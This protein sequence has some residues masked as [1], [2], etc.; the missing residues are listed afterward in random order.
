MNDKLDLAPLEPETQ[1]RA[2]LGLWVAARLRNALS[3][4][5]VLAAP[6]FYAGYVWAKSGGA[7]AFFGSMTIACTV[8]GV[9][10]LYR[11]FQS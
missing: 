8:L 1:F 7:E 6:F 9:V 11:S 3:H 10:E 4:F 5:Y 2:R